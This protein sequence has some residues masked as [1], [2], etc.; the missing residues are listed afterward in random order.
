[1]GKSE[2]VCIQL[3]TH[4]VLRNSSLPSGFNSHPSVWPTCHRDTRWH[5]KN[6]SCSSHHCSIHTHIALHCIIA[7]Y[8]GFPGGASDKEPAC[9]CRRCKRAGLRSPGRGN[10]NLLQCSCLENPMDRGAWWATVHGVTK[11]RARLSTG[12][13]HTIPPIKSTLSV[14]TTHWFF[15]RS[16]SCAT[17]T[18]SLYNH[19]H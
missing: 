13:T 8:W 17:A 6:S 2:C 15:E 12:H 4:T 10:S 9:Q 11:S 1:M 7:Y 16:Q 3:H 19:H 18:T 5:F 14:C